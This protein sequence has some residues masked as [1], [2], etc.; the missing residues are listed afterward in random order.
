MLFRSNKIAVVI[1]TGIYVCSF[2]LFGLDYYSEKNTDFYYGYEDA[3]T[4]AESITDGK[5]GTV[6]IRYPLILMHTKML[7]QE[8]L[9]QMGGAKNFDTKGICL[10][11]LTTDITPPAK[12]NGM[13]Q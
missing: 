13:E 1:I 6:M 10:H 3:L 9:Q 12:I 5:I 4:Y 11:K 8:Y 2:I 7:P